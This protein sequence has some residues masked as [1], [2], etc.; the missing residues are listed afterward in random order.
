MSTE[1]QARTDP[2]HRGLQNFEFSPG[3]EIE[4]VNS[5][6]ALGQI[7]QVLFDFDGTVSL[8]R[9]G[10]QKIMG[11]MMVE[12]ISRLP[13]AESEEQLAELVGD[14]ILE[15]TGK[16]TIYQ[17]Y[18][19]ADEVSRRGGEALEPLEY[20][21]EYLRRLDSHIRDRI[22]ALEQGRVEPVEM[23]VPGVFDILENLRSRGV[24]M[25][26]AS[27]TDQPFARHESELLGTTRFFD[28]AL[29]RAL[30]EPSKF[31]KMAN[32]WHSSGIR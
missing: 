17:M 31:S 29:W 27:G 32:Y 18:W 13:H 8:I 1:N 6:V 24:K 19:L 10:W 16:Q 2:P 4:I 11:P 3:S 5:E 9:E 15:T 26:C 21:R 14:K 30:E 25:Y 23:A 28:G 12:I 7:R 22:A 20:K